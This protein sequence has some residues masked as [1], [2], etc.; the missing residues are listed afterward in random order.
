MCRSHRD[1][2]PFSCSTCN[3]YFPSGESAARET[4]PLFVRFSMEIFS[5]GVCFVRSSS[6]YPPNAAASSTTAA[7]ASSTPLPNL[8]SLAA[9]SNAELP[10]L[11]G[12]CAAPLAVTA[13]TPLSGLCGPC[14][15]GG[16][17]GDS[18]VCA[19]VPC[20]AVTWDDPD[21]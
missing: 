8:F 15:D 3:R 19:S 5:K 17:G 4:L 11:S 21:G 20:A 18:G 10:V 16:D 7:T 14:G 6:V 1:C 2:E 13:A 12:T 9:R